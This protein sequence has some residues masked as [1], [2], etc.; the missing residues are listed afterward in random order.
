MKKKIIFVTVGTGKFDEL[1]RSI[2]KLEKSSKYQL[3]LQIG[4]GTYE[5]KSFQFFRYE[6][7]L[8]KYYNKADLIISH[9][10]AG[11]IYELLGMGKKIIGVPNLSR[12]DAHQQDILLALSEEKYL[13]WCKNVKDIQLSIKDSEKFKFKKYVKPECS[14]SE[15]IIDFIG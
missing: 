7:D 13:I 1:I 15:K 12:T 11:T 14:I 10:G 8:K 4:N 3:I 6:K 9:G 5:P 2:D